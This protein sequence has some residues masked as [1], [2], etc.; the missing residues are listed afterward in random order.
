MSL[1][2]FLVFLGQVASR[3]YH[4][5]VCEVAPFKTPGQGNNIVRLE[6]LAAHLTTTLTPP[7]TDCNLLTFMPRLLTKGDECYRFLPP[8][9]PDTCNVKYL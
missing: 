9:K 8:T 7:G 3:S 1:C 4:N 5:K 6:C 2:V